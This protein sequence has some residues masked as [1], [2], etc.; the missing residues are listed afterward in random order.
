M[1][2]PPHCPPHPPHAHRAAGRHAGRP[3]H[4]PRRAAG[5]AAAVWA[6]QG[7]EWHLRAPPTAWGWQP[8]RVPAHL[9]DGGQPL[10]LTVHSLQSLDVHLDDVWGTVIFTPWAPHAGPA[11]E[12]MSTPRPPIPGTMTCSPLRWSLVTPLSVQTLST[13]RLMK[14]TTAPATSQVS[15]SS[16]PLSV[17]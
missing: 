12:S 9:L 11:K 8:G 7:Q 1:Q 15:A 10:A 5:V 4:T 13:K 6:A 16:K 3:A 14:R 17:S 2:A